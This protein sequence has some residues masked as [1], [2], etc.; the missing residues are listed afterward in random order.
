MK[1]IFLEGEIKVGKTFVLNK[2]L[3]RLNIKFGGFKTIPIYENNKKISFKLINLCTYE[4]DIVAIYNSDGNLIVNSNVFDELGVKSLNDALKNSDLIVMDEL[5]FLEDNSNR[6]KEKV[7]E[8]LSSE[9]KV[10]A[11]VKEKKTSFLNQ[12]IKYGKVYKVN[13]KNRESIIEEIIKEI[14]NGH[15]SRLD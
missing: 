10:L 14:R 5:G 2:I 4:E 1:N 12:V 11:V 15:L 13:L 8:I 7:F 9:K 6:F 3:Q